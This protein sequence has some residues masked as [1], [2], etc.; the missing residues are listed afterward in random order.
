MDLSVFQDYALIILFGSFIL[1]LILRVPIGISL[2]VSSILGLLLINY[3][4]TTIPKICFHPL[5]ALY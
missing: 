3:N 4:L 5:I 1:L 2:G